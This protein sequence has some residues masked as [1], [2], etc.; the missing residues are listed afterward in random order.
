MFRRLMGRYCC[1]L[2][3]SKRRTA[4]EEA[5]VAP[6]VCLDRGIGVVEDIHVLRVVCG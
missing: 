3:E 4:Y 5:I 6:D 1:Q 2:M